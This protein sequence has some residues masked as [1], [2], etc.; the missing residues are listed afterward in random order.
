MTTLAYILYII[1]SVVVCGITLFRLAGWRKHAILSRRTGDQNA[2]IYKE[3]PFYWFVLLIMALPFAVVITLL[4]YLVVEFFTSKASNGGQ[5]RFTK[6]KK[7]MSS[8]IREL[9]R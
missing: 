8:N 5:D 4:P 7:L 1:Y 3:I 2:R 9:Q 6:F